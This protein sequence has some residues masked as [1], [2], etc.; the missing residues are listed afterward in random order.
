[1]RDNGLKVLEDGVILKSQAQLAASITADWDTQSR[2]AC[3]K[4][5]VQLKEMSAW[6]ALAAQL[7]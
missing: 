6:P 7:P 1:L 4:L 2:A 3:E 5:L